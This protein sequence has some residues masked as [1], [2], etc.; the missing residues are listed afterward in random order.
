MINR[1]SLGI[2]IMLLLSLGGCETLSK[3]ECAV[4]DWRALGVQDGLQGRADAAADYYESCTKHGYGVD[5]NSYRA[6]RQVGLQQYCTYGNAVRVGL[7]GKAYS[8]VCAPSIDP[9]FRRL[10]AAGYRVYDTQRHVDV[11]KAEQR[12][13]ERD[14]ADKE[15]LPAQKPK[16]RSRLA[17]LD[18]ELNDARD[19]VRYAQSKLDRLWDSYR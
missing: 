12:G 19:E 11:L 4:A 7:A 3:S 13:L 5:V 2:W 9:D 14:L 18:G 16:I 8:G 1:V 17:Q 10:Q 6:G 15:T